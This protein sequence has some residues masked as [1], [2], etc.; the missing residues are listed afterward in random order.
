MLQATDLDT[1]LIQVWEC[2]V[3]VSRSLNENMEKDQ[4]TFFV[5]FF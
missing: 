4:H 2:L 3:F 1:L 5:L